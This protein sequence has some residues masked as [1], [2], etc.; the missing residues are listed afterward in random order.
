LLPG[1][2]DSQESKE[3]F[4]SLLLEVAA[5]PT[6]SGRKPSAGVTIAELM[7]AHLRHS[8]RHYRRAEGTPTDEVRAYKRVY[9]ITRRGRIGR[10]EKMPERRLPRLGAVKLR[11]NSSNKPCQLRYR[12]TEGA[13]FPVNRAEGRTGLAAGYPRKLR[14]RTLTNLY[15]ERP[16]W[17]ASARRWMADGQ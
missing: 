10:S 14:E 8:E 1:E 16:A 12:M 13:S 3:S 6:T 2:F 9:K 11:S 17:L 7:L 15:N 4:A 5:A